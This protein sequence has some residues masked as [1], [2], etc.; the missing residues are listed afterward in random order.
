MVVVLNCFVFLCA[1]VFEDLKLVL[2]DF[3]SLFQFG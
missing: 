1:F 2:E 3:Y